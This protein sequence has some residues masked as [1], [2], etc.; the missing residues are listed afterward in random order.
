VGS[1][2]ALIAA[3]DHGPDARLDGARRWTVLSLSANAHGAD[4]P[5]SGAVLVPRGATPRGGWLVVSWA[6]GTTSVAD[7][8]APFEPPD[9]GLDAYGQEVAAFLGVGY[10]VTATDY[11]GLGTPGM[12]TYL[13][14]ADE[15]NAAADI[16][17]TARR[18]VPGRLM[19]RVWFAVGRSQGG[20]ASLFAARATHRSG[21]PRPSA[22]VAVAPAS[23]LESMLAGVR[24]AHV[25]SELPFAF[26]SMAGL[27]AT[28]RGDSSL[29]LRSPLG[30]TVAAIAARVLARC[31]ADEDTV[32]NGLDTEQML[33]LS[34][35]RLQRIG[36]RMAA[37]GD[38]DR[39]A[40]PVPAPV[41][42]GGLPRRSWRTPSGC[43]FRLVSARRPAASGVGKGMQG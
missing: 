8:C 26:Y 12:H 9:L 15:G 19:G 40:V 43:R 16:V 28:Y 1:S 25:P 23:H 41:V 11:P 3:T 35:D 39:A 33:P 2:G 30:P 27:A 13:V 29:S 17:T 37:Y 5:V 14:G 10:A 38:P 21:P 31:S 7:A 42:Q 22:V 4:V 24:A 36:E 18:L 20:H 34:V 6:H 32:L